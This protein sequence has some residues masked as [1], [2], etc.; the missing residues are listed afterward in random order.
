MRK[1]ERERERELGVMASAGEV[2]GR[3][4]AEKGVQDSDVVTVELP[5]PDGWKKKVWFLM[6]LCFVLVFWLSFC[7]PCCDLLFRCVIEVFGMGY[8]DGGLDWLSS[9]ILFLGF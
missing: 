8:F 3:S 1:L 5:A 9:W 4:P 6:F 2:E 7:F